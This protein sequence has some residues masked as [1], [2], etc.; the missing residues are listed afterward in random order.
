MAAVEQV[1]DIALAGLL[2]EHVACHPP[3]QGDNLYP[4][5]VALS[6]YDVSKGV[7]AFID[8]YTELEMRR[9]G[10]EKY[11]LDNLLLR[12][13]KEGVKIFVIL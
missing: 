4:R 9:P 7:A 8:P 3:R 2:L 6:W 11:R 1:T 10:K 5:L 12:K 13:A